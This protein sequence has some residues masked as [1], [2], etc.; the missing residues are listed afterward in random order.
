MHA[1]T[2][3]AIRKLKICLGKIMC[4]RPFIYAAIAVVVLEIY[5]VVSEVLAIYII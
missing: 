1:H 5:R 2:L 4:I 3:R